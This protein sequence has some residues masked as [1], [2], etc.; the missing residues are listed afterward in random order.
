M[1]NL[2][3]IQHIE[4]EGPGLF[5][6]IAK[7]KNI[8]YEIICLFK[9]DKLPVLTKFDS[10]IILG[11]PM[12]VKDIF[13]PAYP[14]LLEELEFIKTAI[15][16]D[17]A[18]LGVCLGA[19]LVSYCFGGAV[20]KIYNKKTKSYVKEIGWSLVCLEKGL[21]SED[22]LLERY[23]PLNVLHWHSDR[24]LLPKSSILIGSSQLCKE[25][26]FRFSTNIYCMQFH[27][28][29]LESQFYK[30][31]KEDKDFISSAFNTDAAT[32]LIK[33]HSRFYQESLP[34]RVSFINYL[35][36]FLL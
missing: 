3:F 36:S 5:E 7:E 22:R 2:F 35:F 29:V 14:W 12:G 30:W 33:Q 20:E 1:S 21:S 13:N 32:E 11:G 19:Q 23:F 9:G 26:F 6:I 4:R 8:K 15:K 25:Q 16:L 27:V 10:I 17:I 18:I 28:E 24:I 34:I 31:V